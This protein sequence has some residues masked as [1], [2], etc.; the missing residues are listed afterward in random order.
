MVTLGRKAFQG[1]IHMLESTWL[2]VYWLLSKWQAA[3]GT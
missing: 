3:G 1:K 2:P